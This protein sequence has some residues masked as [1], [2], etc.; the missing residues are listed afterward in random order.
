MSVA[1]PG[2]QSGSAPLPHVR[3]RTMEDAAVLLVMFIGKLKRTT[4][5]AL[6]QV[7]SPSSHSLAGE[8][9]GNPA[10]EHDSITYGT[11]AIFPVVKRH[12]YPAS[13]G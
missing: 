8:G 7:C 11:D 6:I 2:E 5:E 9:E 1:F 13:R 4:I 3:T 10:F 12:T